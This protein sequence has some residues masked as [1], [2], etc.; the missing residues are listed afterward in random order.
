MEIYYQTVGYPDFQVFSNSCIL[1]ILPFKIIHNKYS[2]L[3][4][5]CSMQVIL[6]LCVMTKCD[7]KCVEFVE[8]F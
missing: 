3:Y 2:K 5:A 8:H 7:S 4:P 1:K 6:M